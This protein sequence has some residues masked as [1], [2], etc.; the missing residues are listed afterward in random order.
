MV[1]LGPS[2]SVLAP[3]RAYKGRPGFLTRSIDP[4]TGAI[5]LNALATATCAPRRFAREIASPVEVEDGRRLSAVVAPVAVRIL[6]VEA[7]THRSTTSAHSISR[8]IKIC[9]RKD[10]PQNCEKI[11]D[12]QR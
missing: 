5:D 4:L 7:C 2:A 11:T 8:S 6:V 1:L 12:K 9:W 10:A 3:L